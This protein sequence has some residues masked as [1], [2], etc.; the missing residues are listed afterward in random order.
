M[1]IQ[2]LAARVGAYFKAVKTDGYEVVEPIEG[3]VLLRCTQTTPLNASLYEPVVCLILQG[4]KETFVGST[5]AR[6]KPG[7]SLVVSHDIPVTS[8]ITVARLDEPYLAVVLTLDVALL[9]SLYDE[10]GGVADQPSDASSLAVHQAEPRFVD[11]LGRYLALADDPLE[12]RVLLAQVRREMHFRLLRAPHGGM[13]R[14]LLRHDSHA[15]SVARAIDHIRKHFRQTIPVPELASVV[16]MSSSSLHK[17]FKQV[18]STTPLQYQKELR[19]MEARRLLS[20]GRDSVS[21]VAYDVGYESPNQFS[22]EYARK[23]GVPPRSH[24]GDAGVAL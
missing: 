20:I 7:Q 13:L 11:V 1:D 23:F 9:R 5:S 21:G 15:S 16:G 6:L 17:H 2:T 14:R 24:L 4:E 18:T 12:A 3:M 10:L 8:R 22:R 19:L